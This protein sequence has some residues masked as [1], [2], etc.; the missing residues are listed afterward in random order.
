MRVDVVSTTWRE[1]QACE[2]SQVGYETQ[3]RQ[4]RKARK[5]SKQR[6]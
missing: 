4:A 5:G 2:A 3:A 1:T 6:N